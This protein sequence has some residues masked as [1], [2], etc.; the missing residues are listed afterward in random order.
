MIGLDIFYSAL[1]KPVPN[2]TINPFHTILNTHPKTTP[3][4]IETYIE[5]EIDAT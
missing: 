5:N 4:R 1:T 2:F 3:N